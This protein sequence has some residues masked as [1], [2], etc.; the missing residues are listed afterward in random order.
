MFIFNN[1]SQRIINVLHLH[2]SIN[3]ICKDIKDNIM[4]KKNYIRIP[5]TETLTTFSLIYLLCGITFNLE[6]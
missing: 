3:A 5:M 4:E 1:W 2:V 6:Y